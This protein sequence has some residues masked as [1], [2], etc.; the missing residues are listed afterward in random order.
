MILE[1]IRSATHLGDQP[2][3]LSQLHRLRPPP[4]AELLEHPARMR[5]DR[6]LAHVRTL[7]DL[8]VTQPGGDQFKNLQFAGRDAPAM[9]TPPRSP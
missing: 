9:R 7:G 5:L 3:L 1:E 6:V 4:R 8:L 2:K